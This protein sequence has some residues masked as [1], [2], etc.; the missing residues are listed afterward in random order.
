[1][2]RAA[3]PLPQRRCKGKSDI[4]SGGTDQPR[5]PAGPA[6]TRRN[7]P[8]TSRR[9]GLP[10]TTARA[11]ILRAAILRAARKRYFRLCVIP[12]RPTA[13]LNAIRWPMGSR[14]ALL[15]A[16]DWPLRGDGSRTSASRWRK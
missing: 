15:E 1:M 5:G 2:L 11:A 10:A 16:G 8:G 9:Q 14:P 12:A 4:V 13:S 7:A 3:R 6:R